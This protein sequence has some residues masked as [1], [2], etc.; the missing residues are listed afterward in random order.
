MEAVSSSKEGEG[1]DRQSVLPS[2][3]AVFCRSE[4]DTGLHSLERRPSSRP[5]DRASCMRLAFENAPLPLFVVDA[6]WRVIVANAEAI[7]KFG[8]LRAEAEG[9]LAP[10]VRVQPGRYGPRGAPYCES[11]CGRIRADLAAIFAKVLETETCVKL[12]NDE[13]LPVRI[14]VSTLF[15][16]NGDKVYGAVIAVSPEPGDTDAGRTTSVEAVDDCRSGGD[17]GRIGS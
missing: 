12:P 13:V 14:T 9:G 10:F 17:D 1:T 4:D 11:D 16:E 15:S 2:A 7:S 5:P 6:E 3:T 8:Y